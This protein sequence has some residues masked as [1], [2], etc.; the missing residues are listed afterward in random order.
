MKKL[1]DDADGEIAF[2]EFYKG[3]SNVSKFSQPDQM[4]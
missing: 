1:D 2:D 3:L 4:N